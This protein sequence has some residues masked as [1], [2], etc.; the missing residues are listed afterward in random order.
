[1]RSA[2]FMLCL[3]AGPAFAQWGTWS[4][5]WHHREIRSNLWAALSERHAA[6]G[7]AFSVP[8]PNWWVSRSW[9]ATFDETLTNLVTYYADMP[10]VSTA[11]V[12]RGI[13]MKALDISTLTN[14]LWWPNRSDYQQRRDV[15]NACTTTVGA[16]VWQTNGL[17]GSNYVARYSDLWS[18]LVWMP[19]P[20]VAMLPTYADAKAAKTNYVYGGL[21]PLAE[22]G[23]VASLRKMSQAQQDALGAFGYSEH[24]GYASPYYDADSSGAL[25]TNYAK[26][27]RFWWAGEPPKYWD[28]LI[29]ANV[30]VWD[31]AGDSITTNWAVASALDADLGFSATWTNATAIGD[32]SLGDPPEADEP[33]VGAWSG[34]GWVGYGYWFFNWTASTNGFKY[35]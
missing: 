27:A 9:L 14:G 18:D 1:M 6:A 20:A 31:A 29:P 28:S 2:I 23:V 3:I 25:S 17:S 19:P 16:C 8:E 26:Q 34:K 35:R 5:N 13:P 33:G 32:T 30:G 15:L 4:T 21:L 12:A 11:T 10:C 7:L 24:V 22:V